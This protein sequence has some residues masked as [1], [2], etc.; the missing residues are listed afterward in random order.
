M[1][2]KN[3]VLGNENDLRKFIQ[4]SSNHLILP[5]VYQ[6][7][8]KK[9]LTADFPPELA[10][11]LNDI[12]LLNIERNKEILKQIEEINQLLSIAGIKPVY[13]KGSANLIDNLYSD[14]SD[15]MIGDIDLL[16][17][18]EAYLQSANL[19]MSTGYLYQ[20]PVKYNI[21]SA[22]HFPR[23]FRNDVTADIEIH[24]LP[25][26]R[27]HGKNFNSEFLFKR[28]KT[29]PELDN[30]YVSCDEHKLIHTF[31]H[32]QLENN[33]YK[34]K[35]IGLRD[36]YDAW[37]ILKRVDLEDVIELIEDKKKAYVFFDY[38]NYLSSI[39]QDLGQIK[40]KESLKFIKK[41]QWFLDHPRLFYIKHKVIKL[42][43]LLI[44]NYLWRIIRVPFHKVS[45]YYVLGRIQDPKWYKMHFEKLKYRI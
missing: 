18:E 36:L 41:H 23:L 8:Q 4:L 26:S 14:I 5:A 12:L 11:H 17:K 28:I 2:F 24:R 31:I 16:V 40:R 29:I 39:E 45:F 7:I 1:V 25:V 35:T 32:S 37:L 43:N 34:L 30:C 6:R 27:Q 44:I 38:I 3:K 13:L 33:A 20:E 19:I 21:L 9:G 15:R 10:E 42:W 22:K